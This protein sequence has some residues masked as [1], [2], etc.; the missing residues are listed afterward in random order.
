[1]SLIIKNRHSLKSK[2]I[3]IFQNELKNFYDYSFIDNKSFVEIADLEG[4]KII[5]VDNEPSFMLYENRIF[6]TLYG[7]NKY[8]PKKKFV[9]VDMGAVRFVTNGADVMAPG[10]VDADRGISEGDPVWVCDEKHRKPLAIGVAIINGEQMVHEKK[11]KAVKI[12]HYV[13]D[14][15]WNFS[16]K[17]K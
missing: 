15:I 1:M 8:K 3:K 9:V 12:L 5:F 2:E 16:L 6:F 17:R 4:F 10:I 11:G 13:G 14:F 7:I